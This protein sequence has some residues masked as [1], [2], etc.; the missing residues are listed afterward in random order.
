MGIIFSV[1]V[2]LGLGCLMLMF[3]FSTRDTTSPCAGEVWSFSVR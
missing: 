2:G 3:L 1:K